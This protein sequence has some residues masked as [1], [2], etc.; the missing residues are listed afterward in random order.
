MKKLLLLTTLFLAF[1][2]S[3][4]DDQSQ[5]AGE[6]DMDYLYNE[7]FLKHV[8]GFSFANTDGQVDE[9]LFFYD[10]E[11]FLI[12]AYELSDGDTYCETLKEGYNSDDGYNFRVTLKNKEDSGQAPLGW[13][14]EITYVN[15]SLSSGGVITS[16]YTY[17]LKWKNSIKS[18]Y[19]AN[20]V[21]SVTVKE[22]LYDEEGPEKI[23][24]KIAAAQSYFCD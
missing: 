9:Y 24:T 6:P 1:A 2:C 23:Y 10:T 5:T 19:Y 14:V 7:P 15:E 3:S 13:I 22:G 4:E 16:V 12:E 18:A 11:S 20:E 8:D 17:T 21:E